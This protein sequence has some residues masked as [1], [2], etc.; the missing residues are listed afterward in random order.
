MLSEAA[1]RDLLAKHD[2]ARAL[3]A[4]YPPGQE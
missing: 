2:L 3:E 4:D 1:E